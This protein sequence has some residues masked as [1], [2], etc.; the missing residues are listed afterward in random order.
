MRAQI[1]SDTP[2]LNGPEALIQP[3]TGTDGG[4]ALVGVIGTVPSAMTAS[5]RPP[6]R[7]QSRGT[8]RALVGSTA[9][10]RANPSLLPAV[11]QWLLDRPPIPVAE[12]APMRSR[13][14]R[15]AS[16]AAGAVLA[17]LLAVGL[18]RRGAR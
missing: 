10:L 3:I 8:L 11:A 7:A 15:I 18:R 13:G 2:L 6:L 12:V 1:P 4:P 14:R 16:G 17:L 5:G 9:L